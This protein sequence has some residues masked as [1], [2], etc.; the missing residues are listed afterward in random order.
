MSAKLLRRVARVRR[1][2][3][4]RSLVAPRKYA[5]LLNEWEMWVSS[6]ISR[7][8]T[9]ELFFFLLLLTDLTWLFFVDAFARAFV[10]P[11]KRT[12]WFVFIILRAHKILCETRWNL[13]KGGVVSRTCLCGAGAE[14]LYILLFANINL[15]C[16]L[17]FFINCFQLFWNSLLRVSILL[18]LLVNLSSITCIALLLNWCISPAKT[19][20]NQQISTSVKILP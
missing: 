15:L 9:K 4:H 10:F 20:V 1:R 13:F 2:A 11:Q 19:T 16:S 3:A 18:K 12:Q 7:P 17:L 6:K 8:F 14:V 5:K